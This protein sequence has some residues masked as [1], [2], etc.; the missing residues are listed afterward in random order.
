MKHIGNEIDRIIREKR[1]KQKDL[2]EK[3]GMSAVNLSKIL[4]KNSI[5]AE[6]L[7]HISEELNV[8][9]TI[10]YTESQGVEGKF[11]FAD[12]GSKNKYINGN[13]NL[14]LSDTSIGAMDKGSDISALFHNI[15]LLENIII[16][17][18][19]IIEEKD[20]HLAEKE[21]LIKI[22]LSNNKTQQ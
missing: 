10:F 14:V 13:G 9:V 16:Q 12:I 1:I 21:R 7:E 4:K 5:D 2:A 11:S 18:D 15:K 20:H 17:K 19:R 3:L 8:P 22:L 6:L